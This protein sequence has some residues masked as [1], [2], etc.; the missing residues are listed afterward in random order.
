MYS[1][2]FLPFFPSL[3]RFSFLLFLPSYLLTLLP[4]LFCQKPFYFQTQKMDTFVLQSLGL[5][6][7]PPVLDGSDDSLFVLLEKI[8]DCPTK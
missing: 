3:F 2:S 7:E 1:L 6:N 8:G 4:S 5:S